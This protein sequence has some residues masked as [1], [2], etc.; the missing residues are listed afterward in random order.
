MGAI[1]ALVRAGRNISGRRYWPVCPVTGNV[2]TRA[3]Q[4]WCY[5]SRAGWHWIGH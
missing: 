2:Q 4:G 5:C 3:H 1:A